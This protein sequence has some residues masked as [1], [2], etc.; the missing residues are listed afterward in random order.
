MR[1]R[2]YV[3]SNNGSK[4]EYQK[5]RINWLELRPVIL[6]G[7]VKL[8]KM[9]KEGGLPVNAIPLQIEFCFTRKALYALL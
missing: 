2:R 5:R 6:E 4:I 8:K 9:T 3:Y 7:E 1:I